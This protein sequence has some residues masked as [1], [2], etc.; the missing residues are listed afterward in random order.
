MAHEHSSG[1]PDAYLRTHGAPDWARLV[2]PEMRFL[3]GAELNELQ[4]LEHRRTMRG[5][6][7]V[8][9]DGD[10]VSG[11]DIIVT[12]DPEPATTVT[13]TLTDGRIYAE[14]D[15]R[16]VAGTVIPGVPGT[17]TVK[18][19]IRIQKTLVTHIEDPSLLGL[20]PGSEAENEP[21]AA[22]EVETAVWALADDDQDGV[23][24]EVYALLDG[25]PIDQT[26]PP[27][28]TPINAQIAR[29]DSDAHGHYIVEGCA[30][31]ALGKVG[32]DQKFSIEAGKANVHGFKRTREHAIS[33]VEPEA[34]DLETITAEAH[35]YTS[36]DGV[37]VAVAVNRPPIAAVSVVVVVKRMTEPVIRGGVPGGVDT[38]SK[39][40]VVAIESVVQGGTTFTETTDY[41]LSG[42]DIS[43]A[44]AGAEPAGSSS[45]DVTYLYN[46]AQ[47]PDSVTDTVV[48]V[49][50]GITGTP[51]LISYTSKLPR[52]DLMCL[53][54]DGTPVY[55]KGISARIGAVP[56][57][58]P[59]DLLKLAEI[60]NDW[61][62]TPRVVNNGT[63]R[64]TFDY[65]IRLFDLMLRMA[66][67]FDRS[68]AARDI[69][70]RAPVAKEGIFTDRFVDDF[71]R[72][73]GEPQTASSTDG[74]LSLAI[75]RVALIELNQTHES[76]PYSE[77]VILAQPLRTSELKINPYA[78]FTA[79]P[80]GL[81]L[82]PSVDFFTEEQEV[83]LSGVTREFQTAPGRPPGTTTFTE[84]VSDRSEAARF[85]RQI[86]V[87]FTLEGFGVGENL[88]AL[89]FDGEDVTPAGPLSADT[90]GDITGT[91]MIPA[92]VPVGSRLVRG[93]GAAGSFAEALY[94][95]SGTIRTQ[96]LRRVTLVARAAPPP[97]PPPQA[98]VVVPPVQWAP[99]RTRW[100]DPF[101]DGG[102]NGR[103]PLA[104][105]FRLTAP[106]AI[107]GVNIRFG[108]IGDPSNNV[109]VQLALVENGLPT[110]DVL[111]EAFVPMAT[112][113][114]G[115]KVEARF[116]SPVYLDGSR[117]Y[118]FVFMTD[119]PD[120][121]LEI[122]RLGDVITHPDGSQERVGA[123][124]YPVGELLAS[125]NR[126]T[127]TP[128]PEADLHFEIVAAV[129]TA[130]ERSVDLWTGEWSS[131]S[132]VVVRGGIELPTANTAVRFEIVRTNG[133]VIPLA[134]GQTHAFTEYVTETVTLR[135]VLTGTEHAAPVLHPGVRLA[136]GRIRTSGTYV[137]RVF[138]MGDP[139][140][141]T[142][143]FA[144]MVP[145]G[146][147][148][149]VEADAA[150]DT[151]SA[152]TLGPTGVLGGGWTE[153][154]YTLAGH[155]AGN[156]GRIRITLTGGPANRPFLANL[157]A[158]SV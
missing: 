54:I 77:E 131:V 101:A 72:D 59:D 115:E 69:L 27:S 61:R 119:D 24:V 31:I 94:V 25:A 14:G 75:D 13:V 79:M 74:V 35:S 23:F 117:E 118:C 121:T 116:R 141:V 33:H 125:S 151:W 63:T 44:P 96:T 56:P 28:L 110:E 89:T 142:A 1:L 98:V 136:T 146:A 47:T 11:A 57:R 114:A 76:L 156:G 10:R 80:A 82:E 60:H 12:R 29:Y 49:S 15:V 38:L 140:D 91:F 138:A 62:T 7:M 45:Y 122:S 143:L 67:Q 8:A 22:R 26:P 153:P 87:T 92:N 42:D 113:V 30:V 41:T 66:R 34:P 128:I 3:Q 9:K 43:W 93:E 71:Y 83:W 145:S 147:S 112:V 158:F 124:P 68:E 32:L 111:A 78:N 53:G 109:R 135:S 36:P 108:T 155:A 104:Q 90:N 21:G 126:S 18:V 157:R 52:I 144:A 55:V 65:Q 129:Y 127:W 107:T 64:I 137:T 133:D 39:S 50:Q 154:Q 17:G 37:A 132:D 103:D 16:P 51:I 73:Q 99:Q 6:N 40:S 120:H 139:A 105:T 81:T 97:P 5:L 149:T 134:E 48:T 58:A 106:R 88:A 20:A 46:E 95:S 152:M 130:T 148:V 85:I 123:Q 102:D 70:E 2:F 4:H 150:N 86:E 19:G 84:T 100:R